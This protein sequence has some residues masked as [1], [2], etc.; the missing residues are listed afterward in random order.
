M[1]TK[2]FTAKK[3]Y[4]WVVITLCAFFLFYKYILQIYPGPITNDLQREFNLSATGLGNLAATSFYSYTIMQLFVGILI[5]RFGTRALAS[6]ALLLSSASLIWFSYA[7]SLDSAIISR[8]LMGL[9]IAFATVS[10]MKMAAVWFPP[11]QFAFVAGLLVTAAMIGAIFGQAPL[12]L[13]FAKYGWRASL[14]VWGIIGLIFAILYLLVLRDKVHASESLELPEKVAPTNYWHN[15]KLVFTRKQN[16]LLTVYSGL[17]FSPIIVFA[18]LWGHPF[19]QQA[20]QLKSTQVAIFTTLSFAGLAIGGPLLGVIADHFMS[21]RKVMVYGVTASLI[22]LVLVL[23]VPHL[24]LVLLSVLMFIFGLGTGAFMLGFAVGRLN[25]PVAAAATVVALINT[26]DAIFG[27]CTEPMVGK[28][29]DLGWSGKISNG[30]HYFSVNDY[31]HAMLI[32][33]LYLLLAL[34]SLIWI[35]EK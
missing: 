30:V 33:P 16:W 26:G 10:Y 9:G 18:G 34:L 4:P 14:L 13:M 32:L 7:H 24:S 11:N 20:Y 3:H 21:K 23:Y 35:K 22:A 6:L 28:F 27:A 15:M 8:L 31:R 5:D 12:A 1:K 19:L 17:A 29:L 25:N 2:H